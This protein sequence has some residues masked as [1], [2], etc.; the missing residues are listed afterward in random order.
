MNRLTATLVVALLVLVC[1][2]QAAHAHDYWNNWTGKPWARGAA[3]STYQEWDLTQ[4]PGPNPT[5]QSN[6][7][8][9]PLLT[10]QN[11]QYPYTVLGPDGGP[12]PV[13]N[14]GYFRLGEDGTL[15]MIPGAIDLFVPN[16][17]SANALKLIY[18]QITADQPL[19][20]MTTFPLIPSLP[21]PVIFKPIRVFSRAPLVRIFFN[22]SGS[23][24]KG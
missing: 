1:M 16:N 14:L 6:P 7:Y 15:L 20:S 4:S 18:A 17:P 5:A 2:G 23:K 8:G 19:L 11:G 13:W 22:F 3:G 24:A 9:T 10:T 21:S 12:V